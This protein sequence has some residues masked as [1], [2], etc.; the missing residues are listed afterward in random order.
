M[1]DIEAKTPLFKQYLKFKRQFPD[2]IVFYRMGDFY[3][4][5]GDDAIEGAKILGIALTSRAHGKAEKIPL[6]G[7][8][9][10][11]AERY[12]S[13]LAAAG[14]KVV[15][16]EQVEDPRFA[17]GIVKRDV[18]E[19]L[20]PG[21][22]MLEGAL[23]AGDRQFLVGLVGP[24]E[25]KGALKSQHRTWG[26]A[27]AD[28]TT[29]T[30]IYDECSEAE[31]AASMVAWGPREIVVPESLTDHP[32]ITDLEIAISTLPDWRF[33]ETEAI[34]LLQKH[35]GTATLAGFGV[36]G[37]SPGIRAAGGVLYYLQDTKRAGLTH[38]TGISQVI[39]GETMALDAATITN[40]ELLANRQTGN[41]AE[42]LLGLLD[43]C[44]TPMGRRLLKDWVVAPLLFADKI[45]ARLD[46]VEYLLH[47]RSKLAEFT[48][49]VAGIFDLERFLGRL[50]TDRINARDLKSLANALGLLPELARI[51]TE[52]PELLRT[53]AE[54][55]PDFDELAGTLQRALTDDPPLALTEGGLIRPEY[56]A[57]LDK[58]VE[59]IRESREYL[60]SLQ[61]ILRKQTGIPSLKIGYNR[62]F[63]YYIE[64]THAH[65]DKVPAEWV[66]K[67]TLVN[68]ERYITEQMKSAEELIRPGIQFVPRIA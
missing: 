64:V 14:K 37:P 61:T 41:R 67:Q 8:P 30:F 34:E 3:E 48:K 26:V 21:T 23:S 32:A 12:L 38:I 2:H 24:P 54:R 33:A 22:L 46:A 42:S 49:L 10:H 15:V 25:A 29:G 1:T 68:A 39:R 36:D 5:F 16:C 31:I 58:L 55:I 59:S 53:A 51:F 43:R 9:Y 66:R 40:L 35:F 27:A 47:D 45:D 56:S 62:V 28:V 6:A 57:K 20:T 4:M 11:A 7:V 50:G 65:K 63:G 17:K 44:V 18:V 19:I 60:A 52:S 13:K